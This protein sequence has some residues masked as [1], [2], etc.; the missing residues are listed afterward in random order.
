MYEIG[1]ASS[2]TTI[3]CN[4]PGNWSSSKLA[5]GRRYTMEY[6]FTRAFVP[7]RDQARSRIVGE[8]AGR[9]QVATWQINHFNT[10]FYDVVVKRNGR[11]IDSRYEYRSRALNVLNNKLTTETSFVDTGSFRAPVY[12]KNTECR[13]IVESDSYLPVTITG[14]I[15][16]GNYND[17]SRSVG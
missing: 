5:I 10:G 1:S 13:V 8:Q 6:E 3:T 17:R 7:S 4:V 14:A 2:G 15:W 11:A 12:S 9:L 16:E